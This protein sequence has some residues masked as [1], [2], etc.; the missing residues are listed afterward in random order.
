M[1]SYILFSKWVRV[2]VA[3][4]KTRVGGLKLV[5]SITRREGKNVVSRLGEQG[6]W[7]GWGRL[8]A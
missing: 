5:P 2:A 3:S 8:L 1:K 6:A 7:P 4:A